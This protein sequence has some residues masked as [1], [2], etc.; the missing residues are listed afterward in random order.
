MQVFT[1]N[2]PE[3]LPLAG[4]PERQVLAIGDF[5]GLHLGHREVIAKAVSA[6]K[7]SGLPVAVMTFHPHPRAL[8]G[9]SQYE[10]MLTPPEA[11]LALMKELGVD[12]VYVFVFHRT[13]SELAPDQFVERIL[14]PLGIEKVVVGFDFSFGYQG[15]G[16]PGLLR[17]LGQ[18]R[19]AVEVVQ[20][21]HQDGRKVSSTLIREALEEGRVE[22]AA[23]LLGRPY[24]VRGHVVE[25]RRLGR[26]IGFPT[27]NLE[28]A[29]PYLLPRLGVYAVRVRETGRERS[30]AGAANLGVKPTIEGEGH[31]VSLEV[32]LLDY[33]GDLYGENLQVEFLHYIRPE[34]KFA[35]LPD[36]VSQIGKDV[37][38]I[39]RRLQPV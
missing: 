22:E 25:G 13:F 29:E 34:Q 7:Q 15:K 3:K 8:L 35:S 24:Q 28:L 2:Y 4:M 39:R 6:G 21:F 12:Y 36:L 26:T 5:D 27:A 10:Q 17:E 18:P 30:F 33:E 11:K 32:H 14:M 23:V 16:T 31:R 20:A 38:E 1:I 9:R 37:E 19:M